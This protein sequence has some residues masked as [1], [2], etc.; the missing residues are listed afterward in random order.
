MQA[1][2]HRYTAKAFASSDSEIKLES[3]ELPTIESAP[4]VEFGGPGNQWSPETLL[5]A[6]VADCFLMTFKAIARASGFSWESLT[7]EVEGV[8]NRVDRVTQFT[9]FTVHVLLY[10]ESESNDTTAKRLLH[11]AE[12]NCLITNSLSANVYLDIHINKI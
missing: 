9:D 2:P 10:V 6:A 11:K 8:L 5:V 12:E 1:F 3:A 4:P 7:C